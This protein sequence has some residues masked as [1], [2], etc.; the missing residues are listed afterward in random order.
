MAAAVKKAAE[1]LKAAGA[2]VEEFDLKLV[3]Y[4][5]PAYYTIADAEASSNLER[6]DG[7]KYGKLGWGVPTPHPPLPPADGFCLAMPCPKKLCSLAG[8]PWHFP[9]A[10][11][12][13]VKGRVGRL[14]PV[15]GGVTG[16]P[17][18]PSC[19]SL[20][21]VSWPLEC[22]SLRFSVSAS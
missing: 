2:E 16:G 21:Q 15:N 6:F 12:D 4:A 11:G 19:V 8:R 1:D 5:I 3:K 7:I 10:A 18:T 13:P 14:C 20:G 17:G 22:P 9:W